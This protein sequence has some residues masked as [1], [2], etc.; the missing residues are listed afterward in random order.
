MRSLA[1]SGI[2][3]TGTSLLLLIT[4]IVL[5]RILDPVEFG[6]ASLAIGL[7]LIPQMFAE[8]LFHDAIIQRSELDPSHLDV[9]FCVSIVVAALLSLGVW[10]IAPVLANVYDE[11]RLSG[12]LR[13]SSLC[14]LLRGASGVLV[15]YLRRRMQ[16]KVLALR[17]LGAAFVGAL[18]GLTMA[19][20]GFGLW[21][22]IA[23][24]IVLAFVG[25]IVIFACIDRR[26]RWCFSSA[27][28]K[29]LFGFSSIVVTSELLWN[30]QLRLFIAVIGYLSGPAAVGY[31]EIASRMVDSLRNIWLSAINPVVLSAFSK[32][33]TD[34]VE[35]KNAFHK[36]TEV[37][38]SVAVPVFAG[39]A[40][41]APEV[42]NVIL[43]DTWV[44]S[45]PILQLLS[46]AA[47]VSSIRQFPPIVFNSMRR[48]HY[49]LISSFI[50]LVVPTAALLII[51]PTTLVA[52]GFIWVGRLAITVPVG[53]W[54][55]N[56]I[57]ALPAQ[58]QFK[59]VGAP[60]VASLVMVGILY[61][62]KS[63]LLMGMPALYALLIQIILGA[64]IYI[65]LALFLSKNLINHWQQMLKAVTE[66]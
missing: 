58:K 54:F 41:T 13:L 38:A 57:L 24:Q 16:F 49:N 52:Q 60:V 53:I 27:Y 15:A 40:V 51:L 64:L 66:S 62:V 19:V 42:V 46:I 11:P 39:L 8:R 33:Q 56:R 25:M 47:L 26:P 5:A 32:L 37:N 34:T 22:L 7:V 31:F 61:A 48:P 1:W 30:C 21:S 17:N 63:T 44:D 59:G 2:E 6:I 65:C 20:N 45:I 55:T 50:G 9:A 29:D 18:V 35:L 14:L 36:V 10:A 28:L 4:A 43:G 12:A 3:S 23:Q